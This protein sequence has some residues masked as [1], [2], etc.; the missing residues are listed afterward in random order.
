MFERSDPRA[1]YRLDTGHSGQL[2]RSEASV[3]VDLKVSAMKNSLVC[4]GLWIRSVLFYRNVE[5]SVLVE[6]R[7]SKNDK[8]LVTCVV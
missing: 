3:T 1:L 7:E 2:R 4:L 5:E 6:T 8:K